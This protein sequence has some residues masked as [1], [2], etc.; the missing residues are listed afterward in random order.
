MVRYLWAYVLYLWGGTRRHIG[1]RNSNRG[2]HMAAARAFG[3]ALAV[4]PHFRPARLARGIV[5]WRE[6]NQFD[7]AIADFDVLLAADAQD[8]EA[9][10]NRA[11]AYQQAGRYAT[12][13]QDLT[14]YLKLPRDDRYWDT[15]MRLRLLLEDLLAQ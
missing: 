9:L 4:N 13:L 12:A 11:L 15:A 3:R 1:I 10:F 6:L 5:L 14:A 8:G 7:E 2:E